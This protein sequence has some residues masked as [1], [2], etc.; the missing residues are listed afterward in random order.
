MT[1]NK[2]KTRV[3]FEIEVFLAALP[4]YILSR[5]S[6]SLINKHHTHKHTNTRFARLFRIADIVTPTY[7]DR[8]L[9]L[10]GEGTTRRRFVMLVPRGVAIY[11]ECVNGK[12]TVSIDQK[13]KKRKKKKRFSK[14]EIKVSFNY[15]YKIYIFLQ[16]FFK[17]I[18]L[19]KKQLSNCR[20]M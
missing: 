6:R 20:G 15:K 19:S 18:F 7:K 17:Y 4:L 3:S 1:T 5:W 14:I 12:Y 16:N 2:R 10:C 13:K 11:L 8:K 9:Y